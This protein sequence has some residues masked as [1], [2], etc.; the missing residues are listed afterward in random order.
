[1]SKNVTMVQCPK[2]VVLVIRNDFF[3][4]FTFSPHLNTDDTIGT[5]CR[6]VIEMVKSLSVASVLLRAALCAVF[7]RDRVTEGAVVLTACHR[8]DRAHSTFVSFDSVFR[9]TCISQKL[10]KQEAAGFIYVRH[11]SL[12]IQD[13]LAC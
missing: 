3:Y 6:K 12:R 13:G 5:E 9:E 2:R 10:A 4:S 11:H 1:M 8:G 7:G